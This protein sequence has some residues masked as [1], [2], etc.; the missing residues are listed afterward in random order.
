MLSAFIG[1]IVFSGIFLII[2]TVVNGVG[3]TTDYSN[4]TWWK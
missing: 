3:G 4:P 1:F 2:A